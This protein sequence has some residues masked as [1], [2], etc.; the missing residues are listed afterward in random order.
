MPVKN[1]AEV[2]KTDFPRV[3]EVTRTMVDRAKT[4][5]PVIRGSVRLM[6][7]RISTTA[8]LEDRRKEARKSLSEQ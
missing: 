5:S 1:W 7:G 8:E 4:Q 3:E 2:A 6:T